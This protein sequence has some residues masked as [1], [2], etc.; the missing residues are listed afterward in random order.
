M[1]KSSFSDAALRHND[2]DLLYMQPYLEALVEFL[3][4]SDTPMTLAL[5]GPSGS[6][7]TSLMRNLQN[8]LCLQEHA[9]ISSVWLDAEVGEYSG[10]LSCNR[11]VVLATLLGSLYQQL[12]AIAEQCPEAQ[13]CVER[14]EV[15]AA[16]HTLAH[17]AFDQAQDSDCSNASTTVSRVDHDSG[18][19]A[20]PSA[21][22]AISQLQQYFQELVTQGVQPLDAE[23]SVADTVPAAGTENSADAVPSTPSAQPTQP[24]QSAQLVQEEESAHCC[25]SVQGQGACRE[26]IFFVDG[27][28]HIEPQLSVTVVKFLRALVGLPHCIFVLAWD[29]SCVC[30]ALH[31]E[32]ELSALSVEQKQEAQTLFQRLVQLPFNMPIASYHIV[33]FLLEGLSRTGFMLPEHLTDYHMLMTFKRVMALTIGL[34]PRAVKRLINTLSWL[35]VINTKLIIDGH[36]DMSYMEKKVHFTLVCIQLAYPKIYALLQREPDFLHWSARVLLDAG[37]ELAQNNR[38]SYSLTFEQVLYAFC[39]SDPELKENAQNIAMTLQMLAEFIHDEH[40]VETTI[41]SVIRMSAATFGQG[42]VST[43]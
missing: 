8:R 1:P 5:Q 13:L 42:V 19:G 12:A 6:G 7:K 33:D 23:D 22:S 18:A 35:R 26:L 38:R 34:S 25:G 11:S 39:Q 24:S 36:A 28:D 10:S 3:Q 31:P 17:G 16:F 21:T 9:R 2:S 32:V 15:L 29:F 43:L 30:K 4:N 27:L 41:S 20:V 37:I 40:I 14:Q